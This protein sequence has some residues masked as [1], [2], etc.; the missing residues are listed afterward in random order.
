MLNWNIVYI[1][2]LGVQV[3]I[4]IPVCDMLITVQLLSKN[5]IEMLQ[6]K[7][8]MQKEEFAKG[9][10]MDKLNSAMVLPCGDLLLQ[11]AIKYGDVSNVATIID[12][13]YNL[14]NRLNK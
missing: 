9:R 4:S 8:K 5:I 14:I 2:Y 12:A 1:S 11:A 3:F 7:K 6:N 10:Q 13:G